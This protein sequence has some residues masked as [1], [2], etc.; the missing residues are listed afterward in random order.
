MRCVGEA[1]Y[2]NCD[3]VTPQLFIIHYSSFIPLRVVGN[4]RPLHCHSEEQ[5]DEESQNNKFCNQTLHYVQGDNLNVILSEAKNLDYEL[6]ITHYELE[7]QVP[8]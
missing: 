2:I 6:R 5:S 3:E 7:R 4:R 1:D 8:K